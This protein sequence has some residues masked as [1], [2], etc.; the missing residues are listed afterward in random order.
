VIKDSKQTVSCFQV[1]ELVKRFA[2]DPSV[3]ALVLNRNN[4]KVVNCQL[5]CFK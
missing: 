5:G 1:L 3:V 2:I 4:I